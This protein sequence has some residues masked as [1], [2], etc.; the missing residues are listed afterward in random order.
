MDGYE[1]ETFTH[2][3]S[4]SHKIY[5]YSGQI[6]VNSMVLMS[7]EHKQF[8]LIETNERVFMNLSH[9]YLNTISIKT[10]LTRTFQIKG[11][12]ITLGWKSIFDE[13][14]CT[15]KIRKKEGEGISSIY[16]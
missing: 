15:F 6:T 14:P 1:T 12:K 8:S 13:C 2:F 9:H 7:F 3:E 4:L 10:S 5:D 16:N 11:D